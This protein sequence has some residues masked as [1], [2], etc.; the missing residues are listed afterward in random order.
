MR[1]KRRD[2]LVALG[3]VGAVIAAAAAAGGMVAA[4]V[5]APLPSFETDAPS[6]VVQPA[7]SRQLRVCPGP[8]L[9][10][11]EDAAN[12]TTATSFGAPSVAIAA[13]PADALVEQATIEAPDNPRSGTDGGPTSIAAEP[14]AVDAGLLAGAQSQIADETSVRGFAAAACTEP[15]S[16]SWLVAGATDVGRSG[17]IMI[18]NPGA[19]SSTVDVRVI[20]ESGAIDAPAAIGVVVPP[21]SQRVLSLAGLAPNVRSTVVRV[22]SSGGPIAAALQHSVVLGLEPAGVELTGPAA[23]PATTQVITGFVVVDR[24]G[25][26]PQEDHAEGDDHPAVRLLAP[27]ADTVATIE[28]RGENGQLEASIDAE[29]VAG[30]VVDVPVGTVDPGSYTVTVTADAPVVAGARATVLGEGDDPIVAD[31]SWTAS[32]PALLEGATV[33][34]PPGPDPVL[35]LANPDDRETTVTIQVDGAEREATVP[36]GG[37]TS[38]DLDAGARVVLTGVEGLHGTVSFS[39]DAELSSMPVAPPGP[40][41]APV[42]VYPQ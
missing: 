32:T 11:A 23:P 4:A 31:L 7:E 2:L 33:A 35:H 8:L 34:V 17:L 40:L 3:R 19:V 37:A 6:V 20:G 30:R 26:A 41:D 9:E 16:E 24:R 15:S 42:R 25:V 14:G 38:V 5:V 22:T 39:G 36:A 10:L 12:A 28:L 27:E 1:I 18:A 13:E 21:G 29:L